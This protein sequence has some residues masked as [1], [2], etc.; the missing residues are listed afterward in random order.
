MRISNA[1]DMRSMGV[2]A[3]Q[4]S[5]PRPRPSNIRFKVEFNGKQAFDAQAFLNSEG[6]GRKIVSFR[7]KGTVFAQGDPAQNVMYIQKGCVKL[8][9]I[10][11]NGNE[12]VV[13]GAIAAGVRFFAGYQRTIAGL[14]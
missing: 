8:T 7:T 3:M 11:Q 10:N 2:K 6:S 9:V 5:A 13:E 14:F 4:A 12:A 1:V